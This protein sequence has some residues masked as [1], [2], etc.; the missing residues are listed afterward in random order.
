S[1]RGE[2]LALAM[3]DILVVTN[4]L[5][6]VETNAIAIVV[7][8]VAYGT[9]GRWGQWS[10]AGGSSL[11]LIDPHSDNTLAP[12][13]AESDES[14]KAPWTIVSATGKLDNGT[15]TPDELQVLLQGAG[16]ALI[17]NVQ[18]LDTNGT[19]RMANGGFK[20]DAAGWV[21][22]GTEKNSSLET[23][24]GYNSSQSYH[25]RVVE[26]GDNQINRVRTLLTSPLASG[27]ANVTIR[28]AVRWL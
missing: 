6:V 14:H 3:P 17:D 22:E 15:V 2:R 18:V 28:A 20:S 26:K 4:N 5:G 25:L 27:A 8:E 19:D 9:G 13:W 7:N 24:E 12:N 21:A 1:G 23:T 16:E 11:E 10:H